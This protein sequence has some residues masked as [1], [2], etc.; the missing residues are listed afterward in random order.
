MLEVKAMGVYY[1]RR[2][3]IEAYLAEHPA[4]GRSWK[5]EPD[6]RPSNDDQPDKQYFTLSDAAQAAG[7]SVSTVRAMTRK[8]TNPLPTTKNKDGYVL[9]EQGAFWNYFE[10]LYGSEGRFPNCDK[11]NTPE[12]IAFG[13]YPELADLPGT[14][15]QP[16]AIAEAL[17][18]PSELVRS[19]TRGP[20]AVEH[21]QV[22][23]RVF[24]NKHKLPAFLE[25]QES[26]PDRYGFALSG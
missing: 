21:V 1:V 25:R 24:I 17:G 12:T 23:R 26:R 18:L 20:D 22:G 8:A 13:G 5:A 14:Y 9:V 6:R 16:K 3:D 11:S 10:M 7:C 19:W 4:R 2:G 15:Q